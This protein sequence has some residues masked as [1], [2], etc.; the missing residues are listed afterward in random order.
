[1]T[2]T[3]QW[4]EE[5]D[6]RFWKFHFNKDLPWNFF[7]YVT[8]KDVANFIETQIAQARR[9][10]R[11][12]M[13]KEITEIIARAILDSWKYYDTDWMIPHSTITS[14]HRSIKSL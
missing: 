2:T 11:E 6:N 5:F 14:I 8:E 12:I 4:R 7:E 3:P 9:E 13:K 10:E 1:M